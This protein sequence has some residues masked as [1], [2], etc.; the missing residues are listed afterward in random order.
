[1]EN[2]QQLRDQLKA[3]FSLLPDDEKKEI[4]DLTRSIIAARTPSTESEVV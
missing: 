1:M 2:I 3:L 4:L